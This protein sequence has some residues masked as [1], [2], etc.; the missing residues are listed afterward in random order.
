M[1]KTP[2]YIT[3]PIYYPSENFI[4]V[5]LTRPLPAMYWLVTNALWGMMSII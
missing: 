1:T 5:Q 4:S 2:F 3:T